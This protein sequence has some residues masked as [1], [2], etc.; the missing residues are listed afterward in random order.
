[1]SK[2]IK[3]NFNNDLTIKIRWICLL[4]KEFAF[5]NQRSM[6]TKVNKIKMLCKKVSEIETPLKVSSD[7]AI[8]KPYW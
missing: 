7:F 1:M 3:G 6:L 5:Q 8:A 4:F 2:Y